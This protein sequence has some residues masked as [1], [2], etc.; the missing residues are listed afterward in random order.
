MLEKKTVPGFEQVLENLGSPGI[1][2]WHSMTEKSWKRTK[3]TG[4]I[5]FFCYYILYSG[6]G[7]V[8]ESV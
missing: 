8:W 2:L 6:S 4:F 7:D 3:L 1:L 5:Q